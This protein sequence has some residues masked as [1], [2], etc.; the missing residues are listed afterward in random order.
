M[1]YSE[2]RQDYAL[3]LWNACNAP[4][5]SMMNQYSAKASQLGASLSKS[6]KAGIQQSIKVQLQLR[7]MFGGEV[8]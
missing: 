6:D 7:A 8:K 3:T 4:N 2:L 1:N 5:E